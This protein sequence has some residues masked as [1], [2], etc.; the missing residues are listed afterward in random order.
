VVKCL[1]VFKLLVWRPN[2]GENNLVVD[3]LTLLS[4]ILYGQQYAIVIQMHNVI[5]I[6]RAA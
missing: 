5:G 3:F 4:Y 1:N 6:S 2:F